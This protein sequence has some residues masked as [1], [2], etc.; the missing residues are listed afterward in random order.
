MG[1]LKNMIKNAVSDGIS[2]G[3]R[4]AVGGAVEKAVNPV[5]EKWANKAAENLDAA[6]GNAESAAKE[7]N[8]AFSNL[9]RAAENY[10]SAVEQAA[11]NSGI[12]ADGTYASDDIYEDDGRAAADK[13]REV[14]AQSFSGYEVRENVSPTSIGGTGKFM[15]Y[16]F[17]VYAG[18]S[19]KL[20]IMLVGKTTCS[21]RLYRWSKEQAAKSGVQM[22]NFVEHYPN[23]VNYIRNRLQKYL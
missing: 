13:I 18:G 9:R 21:T 20:F 14:L 8:D 19:P 17:G 5:A 15:N 11:K 6:A 4:N 16:S 10:A 7:S 3:I 2:K 23:N 1:F 22:I 12:S